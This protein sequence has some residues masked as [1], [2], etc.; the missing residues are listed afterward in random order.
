MK[1]IRTHCIFDVGQFNWRTSLILALVLFFGI[2]SNAN[3]Y[4]D[5][6]T[7]IKSVFLN[8][9]KG[10]YPASAFKLDGIDQQKTITGKVLDENGSPLPGA[11]VVEKGTIN[12][13]QT[14]FDGNF[15]LTISNDASTLEVSYIGYGKKEIAI[16]NQTTFTVQL[17]PEASSLDE[18]VVVGYG[19][20]RKSEITG[21][22]GMVSSEQIS[23]QPSVN[24]LQ[25]L[26]GKIAGVTVFTNSGAPGGNNKVLIRGQGTINASTQPLYVVDGL[27]TDNIDYLNPSDIVS[28]E[29]L[30]DAS[31]AAIYGARGANGVV[32]ITTQGG[33]KEKGLSIE[34]KTNLSAGVLARKKNSLYRPMN[35]EEFM[36]V[37]RIAVENAPYFKDYPPGEEPKLTLDNDLLFDSQGNP[38]YNTDWEKEVTRTAFSFDN[39]LSI[40]SG[41]EKTSTGLFINYTDNNGIIKT[42][43]MKR[44][45]VKFSYDAT[46][47][48]WL[49]MGTVFR[50]AQV[51]ESVPEVEGSG[52]T[53]ISRAITEFEP[54]FPIRWPDGTYSNSTQTQGTSLVLEGAPNPVSVL[55][56][57]ENLV[58]RTNIDG[59]IYGD[60]HFTPD[61]TL[62]T[63]FGFVNKAYQNKYYASKEILGLGY[64]DGRARIYNSSSTFWQNENYLTYKKTLDKSRLT[65][66]LGASWQAYNIN[67]SNI[68][69]YGYNNDFFKYNNVGVAEN[70]N[71]PQSDYSDWSM[72]SYFFRGNYTYNDKYTAT[73]TGRMDGSS[74]FGSNNK[75]AFFPSA[76]VSWNVTKENFMSDVKAIDMLRFRASY[77]ITGNSDIG[78]YSSLATINSGTNLIGGELRSTSAL[79]RLANP[80][81]KWEKNSQVNVG[82]SLAAFNNVLEIE[83]DYYYKLTSDLLLDRPIPSTTGF[84][85]I[86]DNIGE[87]SNR[88]L[89]LTISTRNIETPNFSWNTS[90]TVN[91]NK[92]RVEAL[93]E[94]DEDIFPGPFWVG[95]S[96]TILRVGEPVSSFWGQV[97]E[98]VYGTDEADAAAAVGKLPGEIKRSDEKQIIGKGLPDY[99]GSFVNRFNFGQFDAVI[100][101]QFSLG[102][103]ILQQFV[104][105]AEDRQALTNGFK[106]QLY[107]GWTPEHQN[108]SVPMIRH[109]VLSGQDLA[110]DSHWVSDG[111]YLRGNLISLGYNFDNNILDVL[112]VNNFR[113]SLAMENAFVIHS[114]DFK[115]YDPESNGQWDDSN[116]SQNIFFYSY[117]KARTLV[118]GLSVKF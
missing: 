93:G 45:D 22:V 48:K 95:G 38:L 107:D 68:S 88:G 110:V 62:R 111:S 80:D 31:S 59:N 66:M 1:K 86:V 75:Y 55:N 77:G 12:G 99:R 47:A 2:Q 39:H 69:V 72:N 24:P 11:S 102:A 52:V 30:K 19:T 84:T 32:L 15:T 41:S 54:I 27:Q 21:A 79:A 35:S 103:D 56:E 33:L 5:D 4:N 25:N 8:A 76:G 63:Q 10:S 65:A 36:D 81:L 114:K 53:A 20:T 100:D 108:T 83:A 29:V 105:T 9:L 97:R 117:P 42:S 87:V 112:G 28:M 23:E 115:G 43:S 73:I 67:D 78:S 104:T 7:S 13:T 49:T 74:K 64:P 85:S 70:S 6:G 94:N 37:Q 61:L 34:F 92:N 91:Y 60:I 89:D 106:T 17:T 26:R 96:Q 14:D 58:K 50:L 3:A 113:V 51:W 82:F 118:F 16:D 109:T 101:L 90:F 98:G 57:V 46:L 44:A 18:V 116:F 71:P 40:R